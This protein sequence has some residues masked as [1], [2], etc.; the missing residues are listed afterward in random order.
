MQIFVNY[1]EK[2]SGKFYGED[3]FIYFFNQDLCINLEI[4]LSL[5]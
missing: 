2:V 5:E 3:L 1:L 4:F